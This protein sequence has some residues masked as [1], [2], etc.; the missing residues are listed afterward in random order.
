[1][2]RECDGCVLIE[3]IFN[4]VRYEKNFPKSRMKLLEVVKMR[5]D[6]REVVD[7]N[8]VEMLLENTFRFDLPGGRGEVEIEGG[9]INY[10]PVVCPH[11][12]FLRARW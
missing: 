12:G 11:Y 5:V 9:T 2:Y 8:R 7:Q 3:N 10:K 1:M 6:C 4:T